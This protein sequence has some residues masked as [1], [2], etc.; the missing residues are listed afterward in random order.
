MWGGVTTR[1]QLQQT[2][3]RLQTA[4]EVPE[5]PKENILVSG[6]DST[7]RL[8][9]SRENEITSNLAFLS[10]TSDD[11][12]KVMAVCRRTSQ[13]RTNHH[14]NSIKHGRS[15]GSDRWTEDAC[16]DFG[17]SCTARLVGIRPGSDT[18]LTPSCRESKARRLERSSARL[19]RWTSIGFYHYYG[20]DM[21]KGPERLLENRRSSVS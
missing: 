11:S 2:I 15:L 7:R 8:N 12:L 9:I 4:N 5:L 19:L 18:K 21:L 20:H 1:Q 16:Q 17:A 10:A 13:R 3:N 6:I 14:A